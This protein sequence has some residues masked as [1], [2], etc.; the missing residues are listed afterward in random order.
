MNFS[1]TS[2]SGAWF[3]VLATVLAA[4]VALLYARRVENDDNLLAFMPRNNPDVDT[5]QKAN[6]TFGSLDLALVGIETENVFRTDFLQKLSQITREIKETPG[7][8]HVLS[9]ANV[10]DFAP[11]PEKGGIVAAPLLD[12]IP[13]D[14]AGLENLRTRVLG[15]EHL[16]GRLISSDGRAVLLYCYLTYGADTRTVADSIRQLV[17]EHFPPQKVYFG[18]GPFVSSYIYDTTRRDIH[19]L[20]PWAV[21]VVVAIMLLAFRDIIGV[22]LVLITS[23]L[24]VLIAMGTMGAMGVKFN[25]VL[26]SMP[27]ILFAIGSAYGL[28]LVARYYALQECLK[29]AQALEQAVSITR[30][31][32]LAAGFTTAAG[33]LS[34][35][36]MDIVP[37]RTFGVFTSVGLL[38]TLVLSFTFVPAVLH[39]AG[40]KK[41]I[42]NIEFIHRWCAAPV[43]FSRRHRLSVGLGLVALAVLGAGWSGNVKTAGDTSSFFSEQS[44]P[45][46]ADKFLRRHFGGSL[47]IQVHLQADLQQPAVLRY[48][49]ALADEG[50][51][52]EGVSDV[53]QISEAV[54]QANEAFAGQ[55]RLPDTSEQVS[56][57]HRLLFSDPSVEQLA[58]RD[59]HQA[60]I[61]FKVKP[62]QPEEV[63][64]VLESI[65]SL[66]AKRAMPGGRLAEAEKEPA[67]LSEMRR[68]LALRLQA[69]AKK[70]GVHL[71][72]DPLQA[73]E[74]L[75]LQERQYDARRVA[76]RLEKLLAS[77]EC[78]VDL[79]SRGADLPRQLAGQILVL[80]PVPEEEQLRQVLEKFLTDCC[81]EPAEVAEDLWL[82]LQTPIAQVWQEELARTQA[83]KILASVGL[84]E[85]E[86]KYSILIENLALTLVEYYQGQVLLAA[87]TQPPVVKISAAVTGLPL[88][89]RGLAA[90]A[91]A[92]QLKSV[93]FALVLVV[94][95]MTFY[96]RSFTGG[97]LVTSPTLLTLLLVY[98]GMGLLGVRLDIGTAMLASLVLGAGVDYA[99][100]LTTAWYGNPGETVDDAA[101]RAARETGPAIWTNAI[102]VAAGFFI[103]TLGEAK[104]VKNVGGLTAAAMI[105]AAG[106]TFLLIPVLVRRLRYRPATVCMMP[107]HDAAAIEPATR[108]ENH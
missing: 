51:L 21:L 77:E 63:E 76:E 42:H 59:R 7:I 50:F 96:L 64:K 18:G 75:S 3:T 88:M 43:V 29:P 10:V 82:S 91:T 19:R 84:D 73:L 54:A 103:L 99:A 44:P 33:M 108:K 24:G 32:L 23:G 94:V 100:H 71:V 15:K 2:R 81:Q 102:T 34:F 26:G 17:L 36:M 6:E 35:V 9:L 61:H 104:P 68:Q 67:A 86:Q 8:N 13:G 37:L 69:A 41:K 105:I 22:G 66:V 47:F 97:L 58:T 49:R 55:R 53:M 85:R 95:I 60:L 107:E 83:R 90:S 79:A 72:G 31:A 56:M 40:V 46:L 16:L 5:F 38:S 93:F 70:E 11:D 45:D 62:G 92:N 74:N 4:T 57:L 65:E 106:A 1:P 87:E 78:A 52:I 28:H 30:P 48:I 25:I 12:T 101:A 14:E 80:G 89:H 39:L 27:V 20:T 98:G